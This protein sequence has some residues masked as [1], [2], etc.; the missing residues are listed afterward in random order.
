MN[1]ILRVEFG[2]LQHASDSISTALKSLHSQLDQ[3][4]RDAAPLVQTWEGDAR[5]AYHERQARWRKSAD[6]L[7]VMLRDI[8]RAVDDSAAD[9]LRTEQR[10]ESLFGAR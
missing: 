3:I 10:N 2:A 8:K 4:E 7:A 9:Y 6:Q 5:A 1:D